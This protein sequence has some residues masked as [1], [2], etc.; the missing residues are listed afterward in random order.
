MHRMTV[1]RCRTV[2]E[3][4]DGMRT[5]EEIEGFTDA[6]RN[7]DLPTLEPTEAEWR[8]IAGMKIRF[9]QRRQR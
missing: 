7:P 2:R 4:L 5:L 3:C 9:Q 8:E 6:L 1:Q